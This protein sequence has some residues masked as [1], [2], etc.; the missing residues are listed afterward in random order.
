M[1]PL[2]EGG[3]GDFSFSW[4]S[5]K[6]VTMEK[7]HPPKI[8]I[9]YDPN[10]VEK[11]RDL[12]NHSTPAEKKFWNTLRKM[13]FYKEMVF[14][15]QKPLGPYIVDF[16]CHQKKLVIEVDG[17]THGSESSSKDLKRTKYL[18]SLGLQ[19]I[20]FDNN[21]VL[22]NIEGVMLLLEKTFKDTLR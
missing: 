4:F 1:L 6:M 14:N 12:R 13:P 15:R 11:S 5:Y 21:D 22:H 18:E 20:R 2:F 7:P 3:W 8:K 9:N 16:Y 10:S 19:V 17:D